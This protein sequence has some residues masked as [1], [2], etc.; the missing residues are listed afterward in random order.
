MDNQYRTIAKYFSIITV[1]GIFAFD[2][3][4]FYKGGQDAT[5]SSVFIT[6]WIYDYPALTFG[7]GYIFGHLTWP[8]SKKKYTPGGK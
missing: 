8:L 2:G 6:E 1:I 7:L 4:L 5:I 3:F